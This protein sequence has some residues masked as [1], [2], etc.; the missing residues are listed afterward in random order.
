MT[1]PIA[2]GATFRVDGGKYAGESGVV[3]GATVRPSVVSLLSFAPTHATLQ[4]ACFIS[5]TLQ[6]NISKR[7]TVRL[8]C[9][10]VPA[11]LLQPRRVKVNLGKH[12][13][14]YLQPESIRVL[15]PLAFADNEEVDVPAVKA[16]TPAKAA[17][18]VSGASGAKS[19][20]VSSVLPTADRSGLIFLLAVALLWVLPKTGLTSFPR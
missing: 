12:G 7:L 10:T 9:H 18:V 4:R 2:E 19:A 13:V 17:S 3:I 20:A 15:P 14:K 5:K 8:H 1:S 6:G 16:T 11:L